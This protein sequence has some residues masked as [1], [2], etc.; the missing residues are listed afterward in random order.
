MSELGKA[1]IEHRSRRPERLLN[2]G[3]AATGLLLGGAFVAI[4]IV[5]WNF[6]LRTY[7]PAVVWRWSGG[8]LV[9]GAVLLLLGLAGAW[10]L[11]RWGRL[12]VT[13]HDG[14]LQ[15]KRGRRTRQLP[16]KAIETVQVAGVRYRLIWGSRSILKLRTVDGRQIRLPD[17]LAGLNQ[18]AA[19]VKRNVYPR[20]L[21]EYTRSLRDGQPLPFGPLVVAPEGVQ[22]GRRK[23]HWGEVSMAQLRDGKITITP[24]KQHGGP[25]RVDA[26][27]VPNPEICLQLL[28]HHAQAVASG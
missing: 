21:T 13:V 27:K 25:L 18:L 10:W 19:T 1:V 9:I 24:A 23:L 8:W 14:G 17:T 20:L 5:R 11:L 16:W 6:A 12:S 22:Y 7:G 26:R 3:L 2:L 4:G 28:Q 15:I